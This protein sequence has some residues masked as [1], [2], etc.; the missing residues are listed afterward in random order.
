M[1]EVDCRK[2]V[3]LSQN[4]CS[5]YG[6]DSEVAVAKCA[7]NCFSNYCEKYSHKK[8]SKCPNCGAKMT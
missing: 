2:C 7:E 3:N 8:T 1:I 6:N 5:L 4:G